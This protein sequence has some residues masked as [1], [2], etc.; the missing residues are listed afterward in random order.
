VRRLR[1]SLWFTRIIL[2]LRKSESWLATNV[3]SC[4]GGAG[5]LQLSND[6]SERLA[7]EPTIQCPKVCP[8]NGSLEKQITPTLITCDSRRDHDQTFPRPWPRNRQKLSRR[9]EAVATGPGASEM[10][11]VSWSLLDVIAAGPRGGKGPAAANPA[12][13]GGTARARV[14]ISLSWDCSRV[15]KYCLADIAERR[16]VL[17][18]FSDVRPV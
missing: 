4:P 17:P 7:S 15:D 1:I 8:P 11:S 2:R 16:C 5:S 9:D 13:R 6:Q 18:F 3:Q 14:S 12:H 10:Q